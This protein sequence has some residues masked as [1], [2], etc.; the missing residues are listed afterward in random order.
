M[1]VLCSVCSSTSSWVQ[2]QFSLC[3]PIWT[4]VY[5]EVNISQITRGRN[6]LTNTEVHTGNTLYS[7]HFQR[8]DN[9]WVNKVFTDIVLLTASLWAFHIITAPSFP[10]HFH[11]K[12]SNLR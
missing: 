5:S 1:F 4:V 6:L 7:E 10:S 2:W 9:C 3:K 12:N 8:R 11:N